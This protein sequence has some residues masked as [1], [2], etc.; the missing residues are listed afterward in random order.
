VGLGAQ[1]SG[2]QLPGRGQ[3]TGPEATPP[4]AA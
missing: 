4:P 1:E 2:E 3:T